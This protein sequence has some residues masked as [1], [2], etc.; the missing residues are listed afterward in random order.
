MES[1]KINIGLALSKNFNK[2]TLEFLDEPIEYED[3]LDLERKIKQLFNTIRGQLQ[4][5]L[6]NVNR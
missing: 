1:K 6:Q 2:A 5:E 4:V 3:Q